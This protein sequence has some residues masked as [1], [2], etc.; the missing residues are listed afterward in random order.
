MGNPPCDTI[1]FHAQ[2]CAEKSLKGCLTF[3]EIDFPKPHSLE[4]L[5]R[6]CKSVVPSIESEVG[7]VEILSSY[8]VEIRYPNEVYYDIPKKDAREAI[9]LAKRVKATIL[10]YLEK[11]YKNEILRRLCSYKGR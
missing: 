1:C 6:L 7:D 2:Q 11:K 3:H 9:D 10:K 5:V 4:E 8:G